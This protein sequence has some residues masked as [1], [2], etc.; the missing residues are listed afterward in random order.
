MLENQEKTIILFGDS[1]TDDVYP[2]FEK[3]VKEC[4]PEK[5]Y[6]VLNAGVKSETSR[7]GLKRVKDIVSIKPDV[8]VIAFGM[9]DWREANGERYGVDRKEYKKNII[10]MINAF[11]KEDIRVLICTVTPSYNFDTNTYNDETKR[12]SRMVRYIA[13]ETRVKVVDLE[14]FW[15]RK[16]K[17]EKDGLR[18]W[19]HPNREGYELIADSLSLIVPREHITVLW[20]YNGRE[21]KCNYRCPYCYYIGLHNP[22]DR[23]TGYMEQWHERFKEA[24][25]NQ[26]IIFYIAFGEPTIGSEFPNLVKMVEQEK[27][28]KLRMTSNASTNLDI[29]IKSKLAKEQRLFINTSFHPCHVKIEK[30]INNIS[31]LRD[32]GIEICVVYVAYPQYLDRFQQDMETFIKYGFVVHV[33]RFQGKYED[34][35]YPWA[36]TEK[37]KQMIAR[38]MDDNSI[39]YMLNQQTNTGDLAF[40][41]FDFFIVD[42]AGNVGYDSNVFAPYSPYRAIFGNIQTGNFKPLFVPS[43]YP[44]VHQG[45]VDGVSNLLSSGIKQLERNNTLH[46]ARQGGVYQNEKGEIVYGNIDK[47]F[48]DPTI[49][50]EYNFE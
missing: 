36:Y 47:D 42:N 50:K 6:K 7:D 34:K 5:N 12:Y 28:W 29:L 17:Y 43:E 30:F 45:T 46:F 21:A 23:F 39:K 49:R 25:G 1:I 31:K 11:E 15:Q 40:S 10:S 44:G 13:E 14:V 26:N 3:K 19:L 18:D 8:V 16:F 2:Y 4:Y 48:N 20:Q 32:A 41:G 24:F 35:L 33:R 9:N 22:T 27:K 37:E 38:Y